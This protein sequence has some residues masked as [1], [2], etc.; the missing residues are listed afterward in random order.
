MSESQPS[1]TASPSDRNRLRVTVLIV[2]GF[3]VANG[4]LRTLYFHLGAQAIGSTRPFSVT[5]VEESTGTIAPLLLFFTI[6]VPWCRRW[7]FR[8]GAWRKALF[9]HV[10]G[11][12]LYSCAKTTLM[13]GFRAALFPIFG[14]GWYDYGTL[15]YRFPM[16]GANDVFG[17]V[18]AVASVHVWFQWEESRAQEVRV[19]R[20][21][22]RLT[23]ARLGKLQAQLQPHFLFNTLNSIGGLLYDDPETADRMITGLSDLLRRTLESPKDDEVTLRQEIATLEDYLGIL[24]VRYGGRL[25]YEIDVDPATW[26]AKV[27]FFL[28]QPLVENAVKYAVE[29]RREGGTIRVRAAHVGSGVEIRVEDDGPGV[30][31]GQ[32]SGS[33]TGLSNTRQRLALLY[34]DAARLDLTEPTGGG[35]AVSIRIPWHPPSKLT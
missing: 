25:R 13:W 35:L 17:Y 16:E 23:A 12:M 6:I 2:C 10:I 29:P 9:W 32:P 15:L 8:R 19:A 30:K 14:L 31:S 3:F 26:S 21:E 18:L 28:L 24:Q 20:L 27:P 1:E 11:L 33:G 7:R 22:T 5:L 4:I 34:G